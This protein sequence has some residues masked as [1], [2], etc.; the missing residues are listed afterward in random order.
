MALSERFMGSFPIADRL[1]AQSETT[2]AKELV[3]PRVAATSQIRA[4]LDEI[5]QILASQHDETTIGFGH[6]FS[7]GNISYRT[8]LTTE[9]LEGMPL[10]IDWTDPSVIDAHGAPVQQRLVFATDGIPT[11]S[12]TKYPDDS[13]RERTLHPF[14]KQGSTVTTLSEPDL[15]ILTQV[16]TDVRVSRDRLLNPQSQAA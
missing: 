3:D 14:R 2:K 16:V 10:Q 8:Y 11:Y 1:P 9:P 15:P 7:A 12:A 13:L 5:A 4:E 6:E